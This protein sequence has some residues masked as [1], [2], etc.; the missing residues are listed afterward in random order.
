MANRILN[1]SVL[2]DE[3]PQ[4]YKPGMVFM[5]DNAPIHKAK[6]IQDWLEIHGVETSD[7]P[8]Y[9]PDLNP[10]EHIWSWMNQ[11]INQ[12]HPEL[13]QMGRCEESYEVLYEAIQKA[14]WA[15]PQE[16]IDHLIRGMVKRVEA[17]M[18]ANG[19]ANQVLMYLFWHN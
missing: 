5:Q 12:N 4:W 14:W 16:Y 9:S 10:I 19:W 1:V 6:K 18:K 7:W 15:V 17:V 3:L 2:E 11:W 13:L 8:P